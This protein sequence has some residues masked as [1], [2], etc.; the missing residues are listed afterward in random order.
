MLK[1]VASCVVYEQFGG[2]LDAANE[3]MLTFE[4]ARRVSNGTLFR[5][6]HVRTYCSCANR[7]G[8]CS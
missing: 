2:R 6:A 1:Y 7:L 3:G 8:T 5:A 4:V